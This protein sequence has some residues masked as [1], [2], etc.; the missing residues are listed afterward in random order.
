M[1][2]K[3]GEKRCLS[4]PVFKSVN[5]FAPE[6]SILASREE[7][8]F[9]SA[10]IFYGCLLKQLP[11]LPLWGHHSSLSSDDQIALET[12]CLCSK[13]GSLRYKFLHLCAFLNCCSSVFPS[14][15]WESIRLH[16]AELMWD[17][18]GFLHMK[19]GDESLAAQQALRMDF[20]KSSLGAV[21]SLPIA[22]KARV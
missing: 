9:S 21:G 17:I 6:M 16:L 10:H 11:P 13:P 3:P 8:S 22:G 5:K 2:N 4:H 14:V 15:K 7:P 20:S 1:R 18:N 12:H 19:D